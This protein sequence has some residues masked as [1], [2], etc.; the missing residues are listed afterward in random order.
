MSDSIRIAIPRCDNLEIKND[1]KYG[2]KVLSDISTHWRLVYNIAL[3][4]RLIKETTMQT[5][6]EEIA[7]A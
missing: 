6:G 4:A 1:T 7:K 3:M 5:I 2:V